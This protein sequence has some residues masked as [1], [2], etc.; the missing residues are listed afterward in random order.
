MKFKKEF[1]RKNH[2]FS[3]RKYEDLNVK[4]S[5]FILKFCL[6]DKYIDLKKRKL[7]ISVWRPRPESNWN[8]RICNPL[9]N[10]S[11]TWPYIFKIFINSERCIYIF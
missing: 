7:E 10:H 2:Q 11:A 5:I 3:N 9:R 8:K 6:S 4:N 1:I